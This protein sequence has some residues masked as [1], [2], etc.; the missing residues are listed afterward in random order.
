MVSLSQ[1]GAILG[2]RKTAPPFRLGIWCHYKA[3]LAPFGSIGVFVHNLVEGIF[4]LDEPINVVLLIRPGEEQVVSRLRNLGGDRLQIISQ[5]PQSSSFSRFILGTTSW[6]S[7]WESAKERIRH[8]FAAKRQAL[9]Q[10]I[11]RKLKPLL[12]RAMEGHWLIICFLI[13]VLPF[14]FV[15]VWV[16]Y[17]LIKVTKAL[18]SVAEFPLRQFNRL[19]RQLHQH[20]QKGLLVK[21]ILEVA[22]EARCDAWLIPW[23]AFAESLPFPSVLYIHDMITSHHPELFPVEFVNFIKRVA[24]ARA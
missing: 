14:I 13:L 9:E 5:Q 3:T 19:V 22:R 23:V 20:C 21:P 18:L 8:S 11:R 4:T 2:R 7:R 6:M 12:K 15:M 1:W 16:G 17:S 10:I 24:P